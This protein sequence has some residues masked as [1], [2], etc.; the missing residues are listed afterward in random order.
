MRGVMN[1]VSRVGALPKQRT[2]NLF[3]GQIR[4]FCLSVSLSPSLSVSLSLLRVG[5]PRSHHWSCGC[6]QLFSIP[7]LS[8]QYLLVLVVTGWR[9]SGKIGSLY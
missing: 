7:N 3:F 1:Q 2:P 4:S 5:R 8:T 6:D 9:W